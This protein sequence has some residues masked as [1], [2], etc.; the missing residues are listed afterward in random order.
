MYLQY[1]FDMFSSNRLIPLCINQPELAQAGPPFLE[2]VRHLI[3]LLL[4]YRNV[5]NDETHRGKRMGC[6]L[7]LLVRL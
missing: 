7:N 3:G 5:R 1:S 6:M 2:L 4:D